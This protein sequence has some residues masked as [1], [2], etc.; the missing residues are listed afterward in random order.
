M[1][2]R[3]K[4]PQ[5]IEK[6]LKAFFYGRPGVGK[7]TCALQFPN[8]YVIDTERGAENTQY[9]EL[10]EKA[11]GALFQTSDYD[12]IITEVKELL[13]TKHSYKT[14]VIDP[15]TNVY[16]NLVDKAE[17][18][19]SAEDKKSNPFGAAYGDANKQIKRL[20]DL[21]LRLDMNVIITSHSK[22]QWGPGMVMMGQTFDCYKK[23]PYV[24]DITLQ[25]DKRGKDRIAIVEKTR[26]KTFEEAEQFPFSYQVIADKYGRDKIE[27]EVLIQELITPEEATELKH[28]ILIFK[29]PPESVDKWLDKA[30][31]SCIEEMPRTYGQKCI[32]FLKEQI[33]SQKTAEVA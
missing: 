17:L 33:T 2:L 18:K 15:L 26:I 21:L 25:V 19:R 6:R 10:L 13:T 16:S 32:A 5:E 29:V 31:S 20:I 7:T 30:Q 12:E 28:L 8:P 4:K 3:G 27:K 1:A 24:F 11:G 9:V 23:L 22:D 14:L